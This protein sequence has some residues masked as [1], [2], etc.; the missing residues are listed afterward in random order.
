MA[1]R[2]HIWAKADGNIAVTLPLSRDV[3]DY[4]RNRH[5]GVDNLALLTDNQE[6]ARVAVR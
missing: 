3:V 2:G 6:L 1:V 4:V 5:D